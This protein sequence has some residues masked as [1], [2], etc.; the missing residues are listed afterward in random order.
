MPEPRKLLQGPKE[1]QENKP[2]VATAEHQAAWRSIFSQTIGGGPTT[3]QALTFFRH[4]RTE[5]A[6]VLLYRERPYAGN[7]RR[8][9]ARGEFPEQSGQLAGTRTEGLAGTVD[10]ARTRRPCR[11]FRGGSRQS[12]GTL[13][14]VHAAHVAAYAFG[15]E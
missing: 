1:G 5:L 14:A 9:P 11:A 6:A 4:R 10:P 15:R 8:I 2:P 12:N 3:P 13:P 7:S